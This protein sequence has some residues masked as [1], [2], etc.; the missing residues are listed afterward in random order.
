MKEQKAYK[1]VLE[2]EEKIMQKIILRCVGFCFCILHLIY[3]DAGSDSLLPINV[4]HF[5]EFNL[6]PH[7]RGA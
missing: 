3:V 2:R 5:V 4:H 7:G 6:K 1:N